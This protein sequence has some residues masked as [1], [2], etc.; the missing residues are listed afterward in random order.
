LLS[1]LLLPLLLLFLLFLLLTLLAR[2]FLIIFLFLLCGEGFETAG[3]SIGFALPSIIAYAAASVEGRLF[4]T[5]ED[6]AD[7]TKGHDYKKDANGDCN[8][9][10]CGGDA[11][12][13]RGGG[14][15]G[16]GFVSCV[17]VWDV[18]DCLELLD[19]FMLKEGLG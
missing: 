17:D 4:S 14:R 7:D 2:C 16:G 10:N 12:F 1:L 6:F 15:G 8:L 3:F 13:T 9:P 19:E 5:E 18:H 11:S